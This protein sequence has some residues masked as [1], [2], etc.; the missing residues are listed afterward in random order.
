VLLG[1]SFACNGEGP[2]RTLSNEWGGAGGSK[3]SIHPL[4]RLGLRG[5]APSPWDRDGAGGAGGSNPW[6]PGRV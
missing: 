5:V 6:F 2:T 1:R 4:G 3:L